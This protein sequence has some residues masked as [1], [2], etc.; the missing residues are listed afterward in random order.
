MSKY[1]SCREATQAYVTSDGSIATQSA[2]N[3]STDASRVQ[4]DGGVPTS[5][6]ITG[7]S[8]QVYACMRDAN[9]PKA[10][11]CTHPGFRGRA[12]GVRIE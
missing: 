7:Y 4:C 6:C 5:C 8:E 9:A 11:P 1:G 3:L 2:H 12:G 10:E